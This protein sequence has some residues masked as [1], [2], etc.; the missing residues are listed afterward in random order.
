MAI[1][2]A[3]PINVLLI[4]MKMRISNHTFINYSPSNQNMLQVEGYSFKLIN[5]NI[6]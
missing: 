1:G 2:L 4:K 5:L 3:S 6:Y